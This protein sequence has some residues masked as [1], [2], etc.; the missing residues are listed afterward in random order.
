[1]YYQSGLTK[2]KWL[3]LGKPILALFYKRVANGLDF[4]SPA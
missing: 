3:I 2:M 1:M 4:D